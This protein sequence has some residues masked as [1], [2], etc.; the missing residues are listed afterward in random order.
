MHFS[1]CI[2]ET[3]DDNLVSPTHARSPPSL[4]NGNVWE[5][6]PEQDDRLD[7]C[8]ARA[9]DS[10]VKPYIRRRG[11]LAEQEHKEYRR[12]WENL[13]QQDYEKYMHGPGG[14]S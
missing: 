11:K 7:S 8:S 2:N 5:D 6:G 13:V 4:Q 14:A 9:F 10:K 1:E 3:D 12:L